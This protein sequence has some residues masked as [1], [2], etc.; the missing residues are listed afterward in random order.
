MLNAPRISRAGLVVLGVLFFSV[1][2]GDSAAAVS[3]GRNVKSWSGLG[4][5]GNQITITFSTPADASGSQNYS[6]CTS[7]SD[8]LL[9]TGVPSNWTL[10]GWIQVSYDFG[11]GVQ[12]VIPRGNYT[13]KQTG[14]LNQTVYYPP[15]YGWPLIP[16]TNTRLL[17]IGLAIAIRDDLG[18]SVTW[19][20][21]GVIGPSQNWSVNCTSPSAPAISI[22]KYTNGYDANDPNGIGVP[23]LAPTAPITWT[24]TL[25]NT[26]TVPVAE[27]YLD[28]TDNQMSGRLQSYQVISGNGDQVF[29]PGEIWQYT[30]NGTADNLSAPPPGV[31]TVPNSCTENKTKPPSPA[32][33]NIGTVTPLNS[34]SSS[35]PSSYCNPPPNV[36]A[37]SIIKY[38]SVDNKVTW[39]DANTAPG[40]TTYTN[41]NVFFKFH[42]TNVGNF[43]LS[44]I[45]LTDPPYNTSSC[46]IPSNMPIGNSFDCI[47]GPFLAQPGQHTNTA[48]ATGDSNGT[49]VSDND[50]AN[51]FGKNTYWLP[52]IAK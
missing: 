5:N 29:D 14:D 41:S 6:S 49:T 26:G 32:Y 43:T 27:W 1:I 34:P 22:T 9:T 38:V 17:V 18:N 15:A 52:F 51:Y 30:V 16:P 24:Y 28:V 21:G 13:I 3:P 47:I 8:Y 4:P 23:R 33:V 31:I 25:T 36:P 37:I 39:Y 35:D 2:S 46:A 20:N 48:T 45:T 42:V 44:N 10:D 50:V 7:A 19:V 40:P 11:N 12:Q